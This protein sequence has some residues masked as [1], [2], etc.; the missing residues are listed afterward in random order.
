MN[1]DG[2]SSETPSGNQPAPSPS[3][4]GARRRPLF[5]A[6]AVGLPTLLGVAVI[7]AVMIHQERLVIDWAAKTWKFQQPPIYL[8]EPGFEV[9]GHRYLF[10][11]ELGWKNVPNWRAATRGKTLTINSKGLRDRE[12]PYDRVPGKKRILVL[13]DSFTWG[14]GVS[15]EE[16][17]TE[18]LEGRLAEDGRD[19]EIINTGVSG[20]G[21]DQEYLFLLREG[22]KYKPDV[23]MLALY[24]F[25]DP[26]NNC[27]ECQYALGKPV[28]TDTNLTNLKPPVLRPKEPVKYVEDLN[29]AHI[30]L[31]LVD[32]I[33]RATRGA[34]AQFMVLQFGLYGVNKH[35][36]WVGMWKTIEA[37][38]AQRS[39]RYPVFNLD[40]AFIGGGH[41]FAKLTEGNDDGHWNAYGHSVVAELLHRFLVLYEKPIFE[42]LN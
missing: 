9:T 22:L 2:P 5:V 13:G 38:L 19:W 28:F 24:L 20:Y 31:A 35:P 32:A 36:E 37:G 29:P 23:V 16:I 42:G 14:Y 34:G 33:E 18:V 12:Y 4:P 41:E 40:Q 7:A 15:D 25:N 27:A 17:Y 1:T 21:N 11:S 10:D 39:A 8:E 6:L 3:R 30:T 26:D